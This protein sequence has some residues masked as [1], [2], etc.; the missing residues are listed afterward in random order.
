LS[1]GRAGDPRRPGTRLPGRR[2]PSALP[3]LK[4][5]IRNSIFAI[6]LLPL[7]AQATEDPGIQI[8]VL[9]VGA[10]PDTPPPPALAVISPE[11]KAAP[12]E[13]LRFNVSQPVLQ[14]KAPAVRVY[15]RQDL[16]TYLA[17]R[18]ET[19]PVP[20]LE[21]LL[22]QDSER[23]MVIAE[24]DPKGAGAWTYRAFPEDARDF[25]GG[26]RLFLN[27][28][29]VQLSGFAGDAAFEV[30][31]QGSRLV[32]PSKV[33]GDADRQNV[34]VF[35]AAQGRRLPVAST[36]WTFDPSQRGIVIVYADQALTRFRLLAIPDNVP[37]GRLSAR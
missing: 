3:S 30:P 33:G 4:F 17:E 35:A 22:P 12:L 15:R 13:F 20:L 27:L 36:R 24:P 28:T 19:P 23:C 8:R 29:R 32:K 14:K 16:E 21:Y 2:G 31:A 5:A 25:P 1:I 26:S 37:S 11:G 9:A 18:P 10:A 34:Q 6:L 7:G